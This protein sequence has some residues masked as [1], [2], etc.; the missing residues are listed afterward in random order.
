VPFLTGGSPSGLCKLSITL[1][2]DEHIRRAAA[3][4]LFDLTLPYNWETG[5]AATADEIAD[6]IRPFY[7]TIQILCY[8]RLADGSAELLVDDSSVYLTE[9]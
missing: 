5:G 8:G 3:G 6:A 7:A 2:G 4:A 9:G 1:P